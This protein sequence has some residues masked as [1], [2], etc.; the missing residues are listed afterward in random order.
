[1]RT[2]EAKSAE[3][4]DTC[5]SELNDHVLDNLAEMEAIQLDPLSL[6]SKSSNS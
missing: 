5:V 6:G 2:T 3:L 4:D 1:M